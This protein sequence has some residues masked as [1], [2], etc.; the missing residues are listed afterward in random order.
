MT[1]VTNLEQ[2]TNAKHFIPSE[3]MVQM[4]NV[5]ILI[6]YSLTRW[7][8]IKEECKNKCFLLT[9]GQSDILSQRERKEKD[10]FQEHKLAQLPESSTFQ[11]QT[12][13]LLGNNH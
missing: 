10:F 3:F 2:I 9:G 6:S 7:N 1:Y 8:T 4:Y 13:G 5:L 12:L 11:G